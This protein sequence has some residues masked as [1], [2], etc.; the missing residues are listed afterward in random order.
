MYFFF[1][2]YLFISNNNFNH[3]LCYIKVLRFLRKLIIIVLGITKNNLIHLLYI[4]KS[5]FIFTFSYR[6]ESEVGRKVTEKFSATPG[7]E[8]VPP[9]TN[10]YPGRTTM[11]LLVKKRPPVKVCCTL[12]FRNTVCIIWRCNTFIFCNWILCRVICYGRIQTILQ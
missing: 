1:I 11:H 3:I 7:Q 2:I 4:N 6:N 12:A 8:A 10:P 5:K 9:L